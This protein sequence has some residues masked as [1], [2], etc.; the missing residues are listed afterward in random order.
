ML[1]YSLLILLLF[2]LSSLA[3]DKLEKTKAVLKEEL[4]V[5]AGKTGMVLV[6]TDSTL[7]FS[8]QDK[9][10]LDAKVFIYGFDSTG[11]CN[12]E[13]FITDGKTCFEKQLHLL[14]DQPRYQW[15]KINEN[16]YVSRFE[17]RLLLEVAP[18][19]GQYFYTLF[20]AVWTKE[21]YNMLV[22]KQ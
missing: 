9:K 8:S 14:I 11:I 6:E 1:R 13:K 3:Q 22:S 19:A 7:V 2:P 16:Q 5:T 12:T 10:A 18:D 20:R 21:I 4:V 17:D 15:K